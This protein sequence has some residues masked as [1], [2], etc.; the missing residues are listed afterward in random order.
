MPKQ[1]FM[2]NIFP[3][4]LFHVNQF[5]QHANLIIHDKIP[6]NTFSKS[7]FYVR[8]FSNINPQV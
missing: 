5:K 8:K 4:S 7:L 6:Q 1:I 3:K 2:L